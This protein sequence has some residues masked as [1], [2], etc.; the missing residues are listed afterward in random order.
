MRSKS[1]V[2]DR[3][4]KQQYEDVVNH[5]RKI[6]EVAA[7][8][9]VTANYLGR[10]IT[11]RAPRVDQKALRKVRILFQNQVARDVIAR[12]YSIRK[13]ASVANV[14]ERTLFRRL[15]EQRKQE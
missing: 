13:G 12:K 3:I 6:K 11:E 10:I 1:P 7:E 5:R 2:L 9:G 8:L 14:S 4:T 15:A